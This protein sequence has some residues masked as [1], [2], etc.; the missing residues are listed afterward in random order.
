ML[1]AV[2]QI[3]QS[4]TL[5]GNG[6]DSLFPTLGSLV[7]TLLFNIQTFAFLIIVILL[8]SAGL[9]LIIGAGK[10]D[11]G[12]AEKARGAITGAVLGFVF[13]FFSYIIIQLVE[14]ITGFNILNAGL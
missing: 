14:L 11:R 4:Y 9:G 2:V 1:F 8:L 10:G 7:S 6:V 3:G 5:G 13:V 12:G